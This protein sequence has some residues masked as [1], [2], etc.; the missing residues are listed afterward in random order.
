M[1]RPF[2]FF[3]DELPLAEKRF[4]YA[5]IAWAFSFFAFTVSMMLAL[6]I[7]N[8]NFTDL[9]LFPA[10]VFIFATPL[11]FS[12]AILMAI[13]KLFKGEF[14]LVLGYLVYA[15]LTFLFVLPLLVATYDQYR[16]YGTWW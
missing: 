15:G 11:L 9:I 1:N 5:I 8:E 7:G 3:R 2:N 14:D 13:I 4:I 10:L 12:Y 16:L 6:F